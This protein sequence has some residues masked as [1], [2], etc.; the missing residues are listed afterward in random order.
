[1]A[2]RYEQKGAGRSS[3]PDF[4]RKSISKHV[5]K[6]TAQ[7]PYVLYPLAIGILGGLSALLL[8]T[9]VIPAL[10]GGG[11]GIA[12]WLLDNT[13]RKGKHS[14]AYVRSLNEMLALRTQES[15]ASLRE[16]LATVGEYSALDQL[17]RLKRKFDAFEQLLRRKLNPNELTF[18]R[19]LGMAEQLYL[20]GLDNLS[21]IGNIRRGLNA[22]NEEHL[23][24]RTERLDA[25]SRMT[26]QEQREFEALERRKELVDKQKEILSTL[27]AQNE[28]AMTKLDEIAAMNVGDGRA[29]MDIEH[30]ML[31]LEELAHR[32]AEYEVSD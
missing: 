22:I 27:L 11:I 20:G 31:E 25:D 16:E 5:A 12:A 6:V 2:G 24:R 19:Y 17:E 21:T 15:L 29:T 18:G 32:T 9:T 8:G 1:M 28:T 14:S 10:V 13:L 23:E 3:L 7:K 4:S 26:E 30:A